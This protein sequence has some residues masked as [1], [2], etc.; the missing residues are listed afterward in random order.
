MTGIWYIQLASVIMPS[1]PDKCLQYG[2]GSRRQDCVQ[3]VTLPTDM[4]LGWNMH[5]LQVCRA[6]K[7]QGAHNK[8]AR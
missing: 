8:T 1:A 5:S 3:I 4:T 2:H 7:L 6:T